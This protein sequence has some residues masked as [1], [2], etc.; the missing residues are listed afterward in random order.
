MRLLR[1]WL[2]ADVRRFRF[3]IATFI[4]V[5]LG[6]FLVDWL[7]PQLAADRTVRELLNLV[8]SLLWVTKLLLTLAIVPL[9]VQSD[10]LVGS[11]AFWMTRPISPRV[12]LSAKAVLLAS[13]V[14][15]VPAVL[16]VAMM[17][18][19]D[20]PVHAIAAVVVQSILLQG[21]WLIAL[22]VGASL[23]R[24]LP[25]FALLCGGVLISLAVALAITTTIM[26]ARV[27]EDTT[28]FASEPVSEDS[29]AAIVGLILMIAAGSVALL[30][31]YSTRSRLRTMVAGSV[32]VTVAIVA[33][34]FW[35][36]P[37]FT[38]E[39]ELPAT[40][41]GIV[42][43]VDPATVATT[44]APHFFGREETVWSQSRGR[45]SV[46]G[47]PP[48]W[49]TSVGLVDAVLHLDAGRSIRSGGRGLTTAIRVGGQPENPARVALRELLEVDRLADSVPP[50]DETAVLLFLRQ[51]DFQRYAPGK[52]DYRASF[53]IQ[54]SRHDIEG[55]LPI[56]QGVV[57]RNGAF[58]LE[59]HNVRYAAGRVAVVARRLNASWI[60]A[61]RPMPRYTYFLRNRTAREAMAGGEYELRGEPVFSR[62]LPFGWSVGVEEGSIGFYTGAI[63]IEFPPVHGVQGQA[64]PLDERWLNGAE[65]VV[66]ATTRGGS[67]RRSVTV[68]NFPLRTDDKAAGF[69]RP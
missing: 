58:R 16:E 64:L 68:P 26:L 5:L 28:S 22:M 10:P 25:R 41:E 45:M 40:T 7:R 21:L 56:R 24:N 63:S 52:G 30:V 13:L 19:H 48:G 53:T 36:W 18:A 43:T 33:P 34:G 44:T 61:R 32:A 27:D 35:P 6:A 46:N 55:V 69:L 60:W 38:R 42:L 66:V 15:F 54:L 39:L 51:A 2:V 37:V 14:V 20:V 4:A 67:I 1:H 12:L 49:S 50:M 9:V 29:T 8:A 31:Q 59:I 23:T 65:L 57:H 11:D 17:I 47:M 3:V 62:F